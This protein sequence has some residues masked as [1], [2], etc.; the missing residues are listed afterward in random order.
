M[1]SSWFGSRLKNYRLHRNCYETFANEHSIHVGDQVYVYPPAKKV[2]TAY[3]FACPFV[4]PYRVLKL[5]NTS[6]ELRLI[7]KPFVKLV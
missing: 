1:L 6:V 3:K 5:Y 7:S 2:G 4:G